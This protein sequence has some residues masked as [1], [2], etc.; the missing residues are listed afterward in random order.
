L[1]R[2]PTALGFDTPTAYRLR[3]PSR[4][5][6]NCLLLRGQHRKEEEEEE[7]EEEKNF[8]CY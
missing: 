6:N 2:F 5:T 3:E 4:Q 7:E 8:V 1:P